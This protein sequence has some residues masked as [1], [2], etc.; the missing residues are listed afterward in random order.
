MWQKSSDLE[1]NAVFSYN[2]M[3]GNHFV[4][5]VIGANMQESRYENESYSVL[6]F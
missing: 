1:M 4:N 3:F 5:A 6:G 2:Q